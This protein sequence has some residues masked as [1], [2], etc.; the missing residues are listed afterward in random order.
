MAVAVNIAH[1][2][3]VCSPDLPAR[4]HTLKTPVGTPSMTLHPPTRTGSSL[5]RAPLSNGLHSQTGSSLK[6]ANIVSRV[7]FLPQ[8]LLSL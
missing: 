2:Q 4:A 6:R 7:K 5:K 3:E 8:S 1:A